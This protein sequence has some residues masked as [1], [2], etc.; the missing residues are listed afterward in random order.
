MMHGV[1][2]QMSPARREIERKTA[3]PLASL[4]ALAVSGLLVPGCDSSSFLPPRPTELGG[5]NAAAPGAG[6][7]RGA[8]P[9]PISSTAPTI[10]LVTTALGHDGAETV[11]KLA[12]VQA[13]LEKSLV[14]VQVAGDGGDRG[15]A[16]LIR[17]AVEGKPS[18][19]VLYFVAESEPE[20]AKAI[21]EARGRGIP[22]VVVAGSKAGLNA[23]ESKAPRTGDG[24]SAG[25]GSG[26]LIHV[27][28]ESLTEAARSIVAAAVRNARNAKLKPEDGAVLVINTSADPLIGERT[29]ALR[30]TLRGEGITK[31]E[32]VRFDGDIK[33]AKAKLLELLQADPKAVLLLGADH[34]GL[35]ASYQ[36][37][38][39][40]YGKRS[41]IVAG[42]TFEESGGN[43]TKSGDFA[44][45]AIF[46]S[47][48][49]LRKAV[50]VAAAAGRGE[51]QSDR[52]EVM[53]PALISPD[54]SATGKFDML[55]MDPSKK[56]SRG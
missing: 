6:D 48:R 24:E 13:G 44:A 30:D 5:G 39:D 28:P 15:P 50:A 12:R 9:G 35:T 34:I 26:P 51:K 43:M 33:T 14:Q 7:V 49:L 11:E 55:K 54:D 46:S 19:L 27:V 16:A 52:V 20:T 38:T 37:A 10:A 25:A 23:A 47:E 1:S 32:E 42:F 45:V 4:F 21:A 41:L 18:A 29:E 8:R 40:L 56:Q 31:I 17:S 36:A 22:V 3:R 2:V 53:V